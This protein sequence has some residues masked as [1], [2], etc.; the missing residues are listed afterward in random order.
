MPIVSFDSLPDDARLWVFASD[1]PLT[2]TAAER[3]LAETDR[4]LAQWAAHGSPL[5]CAREW[6]DDRFLVIAVDQRDAWASGCSIDGLHH[7]LQAIERELGARLRA[8]G[9]VFYRDASG[10]VQSTD[11]PSF[12]ALAAEGRIGPD[13]PVFD[14]SLTELGV[15]R[16]RFETTAG[17]SW[18]G[19]LLG[20]A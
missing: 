19:T 13:T 2:G 15:W 1:R 12:A 3:L 8:G 7:A 17:R 16:E 9:T 5:T 6:R 14:T 11:R 20:R 4:F 10:A 18:H